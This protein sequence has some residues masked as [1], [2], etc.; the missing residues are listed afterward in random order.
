MAMAAYALHAS[1]GLVLA[2]TGDFALRSGRGF[3][4]SVLLVLLAAVVAQAF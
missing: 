1:I 4:A 2:L 3:L